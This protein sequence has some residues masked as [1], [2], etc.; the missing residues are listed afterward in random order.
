MGVVFSDIVRGCIDRVSVDVCDRRFA[1]IR[2]LRNFFESVAIRT[3][4]TDFGAFAACQIRASG[5]SCVACQGTC[6]RIRPE[7]IASAELY[8]DACNSAAEALRLSVDG[9]LVGESFILVALDEGTL[10][11]IDHRPSHVLGHAPLMIDGY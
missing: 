4:N 1:A 5:L 8:L 6:K 9:K 7:L 2:V 11:E 3:Q 10:N